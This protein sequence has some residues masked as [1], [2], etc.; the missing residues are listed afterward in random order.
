MTTIAEPV[1]PPWYQQF[2]PW[3]LIS[4]PAA[5]VAGCLYTIALALSTSDSLV[6]KPV[7]SGFDIVTEQTLRAEQQAA[8][9]GLVAM[10][11]YDATT[12][13]ITANVDNLPVDLRNAVVDLVVAHPTFASRDVHI[14]MPPAPALNDTA[15]FAAI[16]PD[17]LAENGYVY[18]EVTGEWRV[19][20]NWNSAATTALTPRGAR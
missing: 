20:A 3:F 15:R 2:W 13:V 19:S 17:Q 4:I 16:V 14:R 6:A 10:L 12:R 7:D 9:L 8:E 1:A 18:L 11:E 5:T